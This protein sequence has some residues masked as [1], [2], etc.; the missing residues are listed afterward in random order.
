MKQ[1]RRKIECDLSSRATSIYA[2]R[3]AVR[4]MDNLPAGILIGEGGI[5]IRVR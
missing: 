5:L 3:V 2:V 1:R 4:V